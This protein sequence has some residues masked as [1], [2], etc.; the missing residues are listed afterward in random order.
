Q[1]AE[2]RFE[3]IEKGFIALFSSQQVGRVD[4]VRFEDGRGEKSAPALYADV[5]ESGGRGDRSLCGGVPDHRLEAVGH[6]LRGLDEQGSAVSRL[7]GGGT[8]RGEAGGLEAFALNGTERDVK[9]DAVG[10]LQGVE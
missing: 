6:R 3:L 10:V 5:R 4:A 2:R 7:V 1:S 9:E 8:E